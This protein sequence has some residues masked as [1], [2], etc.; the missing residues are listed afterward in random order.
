[1]HRDVLRFVT[2]KRHFSCGDILIV[3]GVKPMFVLPSSLGLIET[4]QE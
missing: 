1:M 3:G 4:Y 2:I